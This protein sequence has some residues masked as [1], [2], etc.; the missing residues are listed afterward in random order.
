MFSLLLSTLCASPALAFEDATVPGNVVSASTPLEAGGDGMAVNG[1]QPDGVTTSVSQGG[2]AG[3]VPPAAQ[4]T[5][6]SAPDVAPA[7]AQPQTS[8]PADGQAQ[9]AP[10]PEPT[11][12]AR[13]A[14]E[15]A[16]PNA[17][18]YTKE[19]QPFKLRDY[20]EPKAAPQAP[21]WQQALGFALK[22]LLVIGLI[23]A[24][25]TALKK[26]SGGR[27]NLPNAKGKNMAVLETLHLGPQQSVHL[28]SLGGERLLVVG[29]SPAGVN[30]LAEIDDLAT[31]R[32]LFDGGRGNATPFN[33]L[34]DLESVGAD[35]HQDLFAETM[36]DVGDR[37]GGRRKGW[38][39]T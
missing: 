13:A 29:A 26:F 19:D 2:G 28:I 38:P 36:K 6:P 37:F 1:N 23:F 30:K 39:G 10:A 27:V 18:A 3:T 4:G 34:Y 32:R 16:H 31:A 9:Q 14:A 21:F 11:P 25:L 7:D 24:S 8:Q 35:H 12:M 5:D 33:Q 17:P 22:L 15:D 20:E